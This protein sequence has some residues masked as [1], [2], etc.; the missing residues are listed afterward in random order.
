M[1]AT[2]LKAGSALAH[3]VN[4]LNSYDGHGDQELYK[5]NILLELKSF[6]SYRVMHSLPS[7]ILI[8][9]Q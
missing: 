5:K 2:A 4:A 3:G 7:L 6:P 8:Q 9:S 1:V